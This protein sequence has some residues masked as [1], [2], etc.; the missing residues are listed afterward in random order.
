V[1]HEPIAIPPRVHHPNY[2]RKPN[3]PEMLVPEIY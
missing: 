3:P 1:P 2:S